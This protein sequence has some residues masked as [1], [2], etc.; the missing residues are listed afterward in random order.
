M[1]TALW[2]SLAQC[3]A[4]T[5]LYL[6]HNTISSH[7]MK[8]FWEACSNIDRLTLD[9][10]NFE[11]D[12]VSEA[13]TFLPTVFQSLKKLKLESIGGLSDLNQLGII[14][15]AP[16]LND[17]IWQPQSRNFP[18]DEYRQVMSSQIF[19]KL[20]FLKIYHRD[21]SD[22]DIA[23]TLDAMTEAKDLQLCGH[24]SMNSYQSLMTNHAETIHSLDIRYCSSTSSDMVQG[25]LSGCPLLEYFM[26]DV[27][28]GIDL[29]RIESTDLSN[30]ENS[31]VDEI[32]VL[33]KDWVCRKLKFLAV[34]FDMSCD[35]SANNQITAKDEVRLRRRQQLEQEIAFRQI[36][37]LT[38]LR[39]LDFSEHARRDVTA[40]SLRLRLRS[41]GGE[42]DQLATLKNLEWIQFERTS[43]EF[44]EDE[45][46]WMVEHWPKLT[47]VY[48]TLHADDARNH[49]LKT[50]RNAKLIKA[51]RSSTE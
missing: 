45:L 41:R 32:L 36:S 12:P 40:E 33:G 23:I 34:F 13:A 17:L 37:R 18:L 22:E 5:Y 39:T 42:L 24:F 7:D 4:L 10:V 8:A 44:S 16:N 9:E 19:M 6:R 48:G 27:I 47:G 21:L 46:D 26:A 29:V 14:R 38:E 43:Q 50:Y 30:I 3:N 1:S 51:K 2:N 15:R 31:S 20:Q 28:K 11:V 49:Q 35:V 25:I